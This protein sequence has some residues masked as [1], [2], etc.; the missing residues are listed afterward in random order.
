M[1]L[2]TYRRPAA[3]GTFI[4]RQK[5]LDISPLLVQCARLKTFRRFEVTPDGLVLLWRR[6]A[7]RSARHGEEMYLPRSLLTTT[8]PKDRCALPS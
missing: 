8:T 7:D 2:E 6:P 4:S 5:V 3:L 1:F